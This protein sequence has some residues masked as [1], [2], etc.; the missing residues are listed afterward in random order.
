MK[1]DLKV[2]KP[3][4]F[5]SVGDILKYNKENDN[6]VYRNKYCT[7]MANIEYAIT[8]VKNGYL[9]EVDNSIP[10]YED[11]A[12]LYIDKY[13]ALYEEISTYHTKYV[14]ALENP[15]NNDQPKCLQVEQET[16]L[17]NLEK[18]TKHFLDFAVI[19]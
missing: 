16:V 3:F 10:T 7:Y 8:L 18:I 4:E 5:L 2:I 17:K 14:K 9:K 12:K 1:N 15:N 13:N 11:I 19:H 6:Y